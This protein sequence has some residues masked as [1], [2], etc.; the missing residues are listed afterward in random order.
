MNNFPM[1][2]L[3]ESDISSR[4]SLKLINFRKEICIDQSIRSEN[5]GEILLK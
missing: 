2:I 5:Y 3:Q 1:I 4:K